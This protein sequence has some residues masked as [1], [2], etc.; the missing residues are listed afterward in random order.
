MAAQ[1]NN[2]AYPGTNSYVNATIQ[3][4]GAMILQSISPGATATVL[5]TAHVASGTL[6]GVWI[7]GV[8]Y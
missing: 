1:V 6:P 8:Y 4:T 5:S 2:I 7:T 3:A